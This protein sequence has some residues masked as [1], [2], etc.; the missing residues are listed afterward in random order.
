MTN[1]GLHNYTCDAD[2]HITAVNGGATASYVYNALNQRVRT[3]VGGT[4][5]EYVFN[6]A[7]QR[8]SEW[9]GTTRAQLNGKHHWGSKPVACY[10]SVAAHINFLTP[11]SSLD[12][13]RNCLGSILG[14]KGKMGSRQNH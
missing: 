3:V 7:G 11:S 13:S 12:P 2:G 9:N 4:T 8:V 1:D 14:R 5:T 6:A 10:A